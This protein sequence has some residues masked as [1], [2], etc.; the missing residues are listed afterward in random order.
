MKKSLS[1]LI[2]GVVV[3][4]LVESCASAQTTQLQ[5][6]YNL[7]SDY[8]VDLHGGGYTG[9][10]V[11]DTAFN[12]SYQGGQPLP[13]GYSSPFV[14]FC[15]FI[16]AD[17]VPNSSWLAAPFSSVNINQLGYFDA[18]SLNRA[19]NLYNAYVGTVNS[20]GFS[21]AGGQLYG[22]ALQLAIWDVLYSNDPNHVDDAAASFYVTSGGNTGSQNAISLADAWL[23]SAANSPLPFYQSTFWESTDGSG[24]LDPTA[25]QD[26]IGPQMSTG[27]VPEPGTFAA[28]GMAGFYAMLAGF[29]RSVARKQHA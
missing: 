20:A 22:G 12:V 16:N 17:L 1:L 7:N 27:F 4:L 11:Y 9:G 29:C 26:L 28:A 23:Q 24:N 14:S 3:V 10:A 25:N 13:N 8:I 18:T 21:S 15:M 6:G 2:S 5:V 19:A